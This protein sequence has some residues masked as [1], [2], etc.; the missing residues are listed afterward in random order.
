MR[1]LVL[2]ATLLSLTALAGC[3]NSDSHADKPRPAEPGFTIGTLVSNEMAAPKAETSGAG[4]DTEA[5]SAVSET[6]AP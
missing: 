2:A 6:P 3:S 4:V 1:I 5:A